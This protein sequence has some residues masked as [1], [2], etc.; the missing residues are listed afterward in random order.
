MLKIDI[1]FEQIKQLLKTLLSVFENAVRCD[2][3]LTRTFLTSLIYF[4]T[5][6]ALYRI[7]TRNRSPTV[8]V[9]RLME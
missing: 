4:L 2:L 7:F 8:H 3:L 1:N 5:K 9:V 6:S